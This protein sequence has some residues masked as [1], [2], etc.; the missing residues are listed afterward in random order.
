MASKKQQ[1]S[2]QINPLVEANR[3]EPDLPP[4]P[5]QFPDCTRLDDPRIDA[6]TKILCDTLVARNRARL[7]ISLCDRLRSL[8]T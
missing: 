8:A 1:Q 2:A 4:F 3:R 6:H 5:T 7:R